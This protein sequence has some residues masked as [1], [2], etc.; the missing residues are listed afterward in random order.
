MKKGQ[1]IKMSFHCAGVVSYEDLKIMSFTDETVTIDDTDDGRIFDRKTG[2]C[3][4]DSNYFGA[5][6]TIEPC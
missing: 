5:W 4:N 2:K 3:L 1:I 6:R